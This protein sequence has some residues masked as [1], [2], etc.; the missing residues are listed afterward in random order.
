MKASEVNVFDAGYAPIND[1]NTS[2]F[3]GSRT[4][5]RVPGT[6]SMATAIRWS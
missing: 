6:L 5:A 1:L 3:S 2:Y 4:N